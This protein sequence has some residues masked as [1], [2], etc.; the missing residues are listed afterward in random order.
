MT[1][2]IP[3]MLITFALKAEMT[4]FFLRINIRETNRYSKKQCLYT[5]EYN[6][7]EFLALQT[8]IGP[9]A[10]SLGLNRPLPVHAVSRIINV[11]TC[12]ALEDDLAS[13]MLVVPETVVSTWDSR[14]FYPD[15][16]GIAVHY[17][18]RCVSVGYSENTEEFRENLIRKYRAQ[19][20]DMEAWS[21]LAWADK[22]KIP[23]TIV[24]VVSDRAG[25]NAQRE[26]KKSMP[27]CS[28]TI[29]EFLLNE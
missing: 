20:V 29:S 26:A 22:L 2:I 8:G 21:T 24:K 11:G 25:K 10:V 3:D 13:G 18:Q 19:I 23:A 14:C 4:E 17:V 28:K 9:N 7:I 15:L 16:S 5:A 12:G 1:R 27:F 6:G